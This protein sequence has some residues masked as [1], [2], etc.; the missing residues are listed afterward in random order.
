MALFHIIHTYLYMYVFDMRR[1]SAL[2][3]AELY[4]WK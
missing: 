3:N 2:T 4:K 1:P